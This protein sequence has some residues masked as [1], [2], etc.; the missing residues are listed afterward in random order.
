MALYV[1]FDTDHDKTHGWQWHVGEKNPFTSTTE[2][3]H[4]V[5]VQVDGD[6]L[7]HIKAFGC[8]ALPIINTKRVVCWFGSDAQF[9]VANML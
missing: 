6:E 3:V 8:V 7:D 2:Q 9:I 4:I 5:S 1:T